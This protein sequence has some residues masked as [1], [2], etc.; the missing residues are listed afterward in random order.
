M[1]NWDEIATT[2]A[3][4]MKFSLAMKDAQIR[5]ISG[6][7]KSERMLWIAIYHHATMN[8]KLTRIEDLPLDEK[9]ELKAF[10][11]ELCKDSGLS[12]S[13]MADVSRCLITIEKYLQD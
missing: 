12:L 6:T 4:A 3:N 10:T 2:K 5:L 9:K 13:D 7:E 11:L 1:M 8:K